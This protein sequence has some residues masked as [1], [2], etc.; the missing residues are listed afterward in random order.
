MSFLYRYYGRQEFVLDAIA[1]KRLYFS[2]PSDFKDPFDCRPK[3]SL[4]FCKNN[5]EEDWKRYFFILAKSQYRDMPD[6]EAQ[7]HAGAAILSGKHRDGGW[8]RE[9]DQEIKK[10]LTGQVTPLRICCFSKSPRNPMMWAHYANNHKGIVLQFKASKMLDHESGAYRGFN[11]EYYCRPISL[12]HYVEAMEG[13]LEGDPLAF[14]RLTYCSKSQEWAGE[15]EVRF[16]SQSTYVSY[17][18]EM[19]TGILLGSE[20][21]THWQDIVYTLLSTWN[22]KPKVFREDGSISSIKLCFIRA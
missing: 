7:K 21:P 6:G 10:A 9:A 3:F 8:L 12:R 11:V 22:S 16:F 17:P 2:P 5:P 1:H 18:E 20:C 14:A 19:L 4:H 15:E 13:S